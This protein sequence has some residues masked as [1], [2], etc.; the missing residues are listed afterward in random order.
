MVLMRS[1]FKASKG[2]RP[3]QR[4]DMLILDEIQ[5]RK[6]MAVNSKTMTC[7]GLVD[8]GDQAG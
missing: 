6:G 2:K 1:F 7:A 5:V 3:F 8:Y 4:R